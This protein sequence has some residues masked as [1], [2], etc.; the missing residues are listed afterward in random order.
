MPSR[1]LLLLWSLLVVAV[2]SSAG[3]VTA[4]QTPYSVYRGLAPYR[5]TE[6]R[7]L[8]GSPDRTAIAALNNRGDIAGTLFGRRTHAFLFR[9]GRLIDLGAPAG[10]TDSTALDIN[11]AGVI[12]A[13]ASRGGQRTFPF[14]IE[15][16]GHRVRWIRLPVAGRGNP[17]VTVGD[18]ASNGDIVGTVLGTVGTGSH[19]RTTERALVWSPSSNGSYGYGRALQLSHGFQTSTAAAIWSHG[20]LLVVAGQQGGVGFANF[21]KLTVWSPRPA[22]TSTRSVTGLPIVSHLGGWDKALYA[23]GRI[24]GVDTSSG[25]KARISFAR[26]RRARFGPVDPLGTPYSCVEYVYGANGVYAGSRGRFVGVGSIGCLSGQKPT[27]ALIWRGV[28]VSKLQDLIRHASGWQ[29]QSGDAINAGG[30]IVGIGRF[31]GHVRVFLMTL[32]SGR[33]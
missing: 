25:W 21:G 13:Q 3:L 18:I 8:L 2:G 12:S 31:R 14:A 5:I 24:S 7:G 20:K 4:R 29:L 9:V 23:T 19:V 11:Q 15:V 26:D 17:S 33:P 16:S 10:L 1:R 22:V 28:G 6:I 27:T 32:V 30:Q